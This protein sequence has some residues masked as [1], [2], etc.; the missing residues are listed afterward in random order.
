MF[1]VDNLKSI[2]SCDNPK[3]YIYLWQSPQTGQ[4]VT[5]ATGQCSLLII[6]LTSSLALNI[7]LSQTELPPTSSEGCCFLIH[8]FTACVSYLGLTYTWRNSA[9]RQFRKVSNVSQSLTNS[10][11]LK[12][13]SAVIDDNY[14]QMLWCPVALIIAFQLCLALQTLTFLNLWVF[15]IDWPMLW[16]CQHTALVMFHWGLAFIGCK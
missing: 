16:L 11:T 5:L 8:R 14:L 1:E 10:T 7:A 4:P 6:T 13:F 2:S 9:L 12:Q 15:R 3:I